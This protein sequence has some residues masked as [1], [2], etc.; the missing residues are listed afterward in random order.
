VT[1]PTAY[2]SLEQRFARI[3]VLEDAAGILGWDAQAIM[4]VG[5][6]SGRA[7]QLALLCGLAH[8]ALTSSDVPELLGAADADRARLDLWQSANLQEMQRAYIHAAALPQDLVVAISKATSQAEMVWRD[9]RRTSDFPLLLPHLKAVVDFQREAGQAK[10]EAL[11]ISTYD[12]LL[13]QYDPGLRQ[14]RI[15][16][17]FDALQQELPSLIAEATEL[18]KSGSAP[19]PIAGSFPVEAQRALGEELMRT[20]GFDFNHGRLDV[21]LHPFCGGATG[22]VRI[23]TRYDEADFSGSL[24]G[25]LHETGH[26]LYEQG[27]SAAWAS[28]PVGQARGMTL[29]ESQSLLIEMQACRTPEF[30]AYLSPLLRSAFG[31][32]DPAWSPEN[33]HRVYTRVEPGFV[34]VDADEVTYPAHILLRYDLEK[35]MISS[36]LP[37][38]ELPAAFNAGMKT[39]LGI[40]VSDDA[41]GCLQ[42][43]HWPSGAWGYFPTYTLGAMAAAQLFAAACAAEPSIPTRLAEGDFVPLVGWLRV[44]LHAKGS[45]LSTDELLLAATGKPLEVATYRNHLRLRYLG[46]A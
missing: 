35:A 17:L 43:I 38:S 29:H 8:E 39:L 20:V 21:S 3:R 23:T 5:A 42:D 19:L 14:S 40:T 37:V 7:D 33:L 28:Q 15:D 13:D 2:E 26:A 25:V 16:P 1:N 9:A 4:P 31:R 18:Q 36:D 34:R 30:L 11:G 41:H 22:D 24:M 27:R 46:R 12:A 32:D 10:A 6:A 45:I 44:N